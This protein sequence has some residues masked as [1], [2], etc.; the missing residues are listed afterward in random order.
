MRKKYKAVKNRWQSR[1]AIKQLTYILVFSS[2]ITLIG[3]IIQLY[4]EYRAD[5]DYCEDQIKLVEETHLKSL[6]NSLW[7]LNE[8]QLSIEFDSIIRMRD[9]AYI[10]IRGNNRSLFSAGRFDPAKNNITRDFD[11][12][13]HQNGFTD[14]IG[15]L[16]V[17]VS[18][19]GV[20]ARIAN[21]AMIILATQGIKTFLVSMFILFIIHRLVT[22]HVIALVDQTKKMDLPA[23]APPIV[24]EKKNVS[25]SGR[26]EIDQL[27]S[28]LNDM[29]QRLADSVIRQRRSDAALLESEQRFRALFENAI[30]CI[31][32]IVNGKIKY[33]NQ[34]ALNTFGYRQEEMIDQDTGLIHVSSE[35]HQTFGRIAYPELQKQGKWKG[36]YLFRKKNGETIWMDAYIAVVP[37]EGLVAIL[38]DVTERRRAETEKNELQKQLQQSQKLEA[39]GALASGIAH[40]F[41][42]FLTIILG[43]TALAVEDVSESSQ[44]RGFLKDVEKAVLQAKDLVQRIVSFSRTSEQEQKAIQLNS[45]LEDSIQFLRSSI[46]PTIEIRTSLPSDRTITIMAD[47]TQIHQVMLNLCINASH[48]MAENTGILEV[49]LSEFAT[50]ENQSI[51]GIA[52]E[53][54]RYA[55][56]WVRDTGHGI[57]KEHLARIFDPYFST[58][59]EGKGS[60]IGLSVVHR[61]V[62]NHN[63]KISVASEPGKGTVFNLF[64]PVVAT[65]STL[66]EKAA[67]A[68]PTGK[69]RILLVDDDILITT[70]AHHMLEKLGY[71][72]TEKTSSREALDM[73]K[74]QPEAYDLIISDIS[75]PDLPGDQLAAKIRK[76]RPDIPIILCTGYSERIDGP[77]AA[78]IGVSAIILKPVVR[79]ELAQTVRKV[80]DE[81]ADSG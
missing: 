78:S 12:I 76:V 39:V 25:E 27:V 53:P 1:L 23:S 66:R 62:K 7:D 9:I 30:S 44:A 8:D 10:E 34:A 52:L 77:T 57:D 6:T 55:K 11:M 17:I 71:A 45:L 47:T 51:C 36:E 46:P 40:D 58:K 35:S 43:N 38:N 61:I 80:L 21:R 74:A 13:I 5:I 67:S 29:Q 59:E 20:Y 73:F 63:G 15:I 75:M 32:F 31:L 68:T 64:F 28:A 79:S 24:L 41:N 26:D 72:V 50:G 81:K 54:G 19:E 2:I 42:N 56:I 4:L 49:G 3:T 33:F 22:R 16:R 70:M 18:L 65:G 48:A 37:D 14:T 69:E 60:G